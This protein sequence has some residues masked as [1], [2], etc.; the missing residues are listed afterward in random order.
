MSSSFLD[1]GTS[2]TLFGRVCEVGGTGAKSAIFDCILS[3][4][5]FTLLS[6]FTA[7]DSIRLYHLAPGRW[8][9]YCD[10]HVC[11]SVCR[12]VRPFVRS[13]ISKTTCP[14]FI[15]FSVPVTCGC[16]SVLL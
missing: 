5:G 8:T 3:L 13:S 2:W 14:N 16:G 6:V 1:Y 4:S 11:L 10:K 15:K 12:F 7:L 9:K